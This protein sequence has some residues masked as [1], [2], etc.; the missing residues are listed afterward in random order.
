MLNGKQFPALQFACLSRSCCNN[1]EC[2]LVLISLY[3]FMSSGY[4]NIYECLMILAISLVNNKNSIPVLN[5]AGHLKDNQRRMILPI[6]NLCIASSQLNTCGK[7]LLKHPNNFSKFC[8]ENFMNYFIKG[9]LK[10]C[11][12]YCINL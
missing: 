6:C 3:N 5:L 1:S 8:A 10:I 2:S 12:I 9:F 4:S 11:V 7:R